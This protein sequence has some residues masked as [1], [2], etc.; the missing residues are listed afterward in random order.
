MNGSAPLS[1]EEAQAR[2]LALVTPLSIERVDIEGALGRFLA[3]PLHARRTQPSAN[4]SAMDGYA[5]TA[6]DMRGPWRIVG[7]SA[8]GILMSARSRKE[9]QS[10]FRRARCCRPTRRPS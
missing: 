9:R 2:L 1:L 4:L 10:E 8:A 7:E 3:E 6:G 5:V